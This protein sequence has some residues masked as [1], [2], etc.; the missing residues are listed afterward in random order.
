MK[1]NGN[2]LK[3][4]GNSD[5]GHPHEPRIVS[6]SSGSSHVVPQPRSRIRCLAYRSFLRQFACVS[7]SRSDLT[8]NAH[9]GDGDFSRVPL[10]R[11]CSWVLDDIGALPGRS[12]EESALLMQEAQLSLMTE[13]CIRVM[14]LA[15]P[16]PLSALPSKEDEAFIDLLSEEEAAYA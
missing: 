8:T 6:R 16:A 14:G 7:C 12:K 4:T 2:D 13:F 3:K 10:C 5:A 9:G 15:A 1:E 11:P